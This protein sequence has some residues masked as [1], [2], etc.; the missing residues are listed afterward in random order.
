MLDFMLDEIFVG[1]EYKTV[2][3]EE[4]IRIEYNP[5]TLYFS[6]G[7]LREYNHKTKEEKKD[8]NYPSF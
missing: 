5:I 8:V 2:Q 3:T 7:G 6:D 1:R 4:R